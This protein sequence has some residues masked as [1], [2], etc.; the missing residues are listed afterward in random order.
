MG[1]VLSFAPLPRGERCV[2]NKAPR[3][4]LQEPKLSAV[5]DKSQNQQS[6]NQQLEKARLQ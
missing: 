5:A 2:N 1:N 6:T 4:K 3:T